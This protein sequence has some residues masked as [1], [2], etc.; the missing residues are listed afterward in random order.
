MPITDRSQ[1]GAFSKTSDAPTNES[2]LSNIQKSIEADIIEARP[3]AV[4][5]PG[6]SPAPFGN[7]KK[8]QEALGRKLTQEERRGLKSR[9]IKIQET[10]KE[11][12]RDEYRRNK[13]GSPSEEINRQHIENPVLDP[14]EGFERT[15]D[16]GGLMDYEEFE[17]AK[18][19]YSDSTRSFTRAVEEVGH[20]KPI[21]GDKFADKGILAHMTRKDARHS[22]DEMAGFIS[23]ERGLD[24]TGDD[25]YQILLEEAEDM[26]K[27]GIR[28]LR[29]QQTKK[30]TRNL[31]AGQRMRKLD[32]RLKKQKN[33]GKSKRKIK[34]DT[35]GQGSLF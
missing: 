2:T 11:K 10:T 22:M 14:K 21:T 13:A 20:I 27:L 31:S 19:F 5:S 16:V 8:T 34:D 26:D 32:S 18:E 25:L 29:R 4:F 17:L 24:L 28:K 30:P 15:E 33:L 3:S 1:P 35:S 23:R 12:L 9:N 7:I 6:A